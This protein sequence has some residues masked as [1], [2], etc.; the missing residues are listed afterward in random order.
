[1]GG[2]LVV[3]S[4]VTESVGSEEF[5]AWTP[6][7]GLSDVEVQMVQISVVREAEGR[8]CL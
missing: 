2:E 1:M 6:I 5:P 3:S 7:A 8:P 4:K